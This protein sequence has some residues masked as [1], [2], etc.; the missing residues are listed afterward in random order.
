MCPIYE[1][2][3]RLPSSLVTLVTG[4]GGDVPRDLFVQS[5]KGLEEN[6]ESSRDIQKEAQKTPLITLIVRDSIYTYVST[7]LT[8]IFYKNHSTI[9]A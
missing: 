1:A 9:M 2:S 8:R 3:Q 5:D 4:Q 7:I 6:S